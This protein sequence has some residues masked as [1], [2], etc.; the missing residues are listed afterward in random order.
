VQPAQHAELMLFPSSISP[1]NLSWRSAVTSSFLF[2]LNQSHVCV[3]PTF[4]RVK[5]NSSSSSQIV[6]AIVG[7]LVD[8]VVGAL[9]G[10]SVIPVGFPVGVAEGLI[11]AVGLLVGLI[12]GSLLGDLVGVS[13]GIPLGSTEG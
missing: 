13:E 1:H 10:T 5:V 9:V 7:N 8:E 4:G 3:F 2:F 11:L 6:G 12:L